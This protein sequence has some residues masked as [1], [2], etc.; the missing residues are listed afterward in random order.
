MFISSAIK[1]FNR[2]RPLI[3]SLPW[4]GF[5]IQISISSDSSNVSYAFIAAAISTLF[6]L[7]LYRPD[8]WINYPISSL[9]LFGYCIV[10]ALGPLLSTAV[11]NRTITY[12]LV[13][14]EDLFLQM[15]LC[16]GVLLFTH[17]LYSRSKLFQFAR[18][19]INY[20][21]LRRLNVFQE[22][23]QFNV[24]FIGAFGL[25]SM[26]Y[27]YWFNRGESSVLIKLIQGFIPF[28]YIPLA[29]LLKPL[30]LGIESTKKSDIGIN[31]V[32]LLLIIIASLGRNSRSAFATP[33][34]TYGIGVL[35]LWLFQWIKFRLRIV[36]PL[37]LVILLILPLASNLATAMVMVRSLRGDVPTQELIVETTQQLT[38][39]ESIER[40]RLSKSGTGANGWDESYV[41]NPFLARFVNLKF[42]D[43]SLDLENQLSKSSRSEYFKFTVNRFWS[44]FPSPLLNFIGISEDVKKQVTSISWGDQLFFL[45]TRNKSVLGGFRVGHFFGTSLAAFGYFYLPLLGIL[46]IIIFILLDALVTY[47]PSCPTSP[48]IAPIGLLSFYDF[49]IFFNAPSLVKYAEF[50]LRGW[51][52][53]ILIYVLLLYLSSTICKLFVQKSKLA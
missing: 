51:I 40:Y 10:Y 14:L 13:A 38:N 1:S 23:N 17:F 35:M 28:S 53:L 22:L 34:A 27:V 15:L 39:P 47:I 6:I 42:A 3:L 44:I 12:N 31:C 43:S 9:T 36:I 46:S 8:Q 4:I 11:E 20:F 48:I 29:L 49:F 45:I 50:I 18:T 32:F 33:I 30:C 24:I 5:A 2:T 41:S 19:R 21:L 16:S 25:S 37:I 7:Y 52:Q 26:I